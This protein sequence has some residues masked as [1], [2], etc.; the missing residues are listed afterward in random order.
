MQ[1]RFMIALPVVAVVCVVAAYV[2]GIAYM[3]S[4]VST[5][6]GQTLSYLNGDDIALGP[7]AGDFLPEVRKALQ[8]GGVRLAYRVEDDRFFSEEALL[9]FADAERSFEVPFRIIY[10]S[11]LAARIMIDPDPG[12]FHEGA[13]AQYDFISEKLA[14]LEDFAPGSVQVSVML[15]HSLCPSVLDAQAV[16][17]AEYLNVSREELRELAVHDLD[18]DNRFALQARYRIRQ[19]RK[20]QMAVDIRNMI[21]YD[22]IVGRFF[23]SS[24]QAGVRVF[25]EPGQLALGIRDYFDIDM[26]VKE[27]RLDLRGVMRDSRYFDVDYTLCGDFNIDHH[28]ADSPLAVD[29]S[30]RIGTLDL[31]YINQLRQQGG[32]RTLLGS[33]L[34][35]Q[36]FRDR[37]LRLSVERGTLAMSS[38][39]LYGIFMEPGP[40]HSEQDLEAMLGTT[41]RAAFVL[42]AQASG[43]MSGT[44]GSGLRLD[45]DYSIRTDHERVMRD[46]RSSLAELELLQPEDPAPA[47]MLTG[48]LSFDGERLTAGALQGGG[49]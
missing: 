27:A 32:S 41:I 7:D 11:P 48:H 25:E 34:D 45:L 17:E 37:T 23:F 44:S 16:I 12:M 15:L 40:E 8:T 39:V 20:V 33:V 46:I 4:Q 9:I 47:R 29:V 10:P 42:E 43:F 38:N 30:G 31:S 5:G 2:A 24:S 13:L 3:R 21:T 1:A 22:S 26:I 36:L 18:Y 14:Q 49:F 28:L 6:I 35:E 19:G